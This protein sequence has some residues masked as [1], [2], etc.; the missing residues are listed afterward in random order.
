MRNYLSV[1]VAMALSLSMANAKNFNIDQSHS[2]VG[3]EVKH[4]L[5]S[6]VN[7]EFNNFSGVLDIDPTTKKI[8]KLEGQVIINSIDTKNKKR[9]DHLNSAD[10]FNSSKIQTGTFVMTKQDDEKIHGNLTLNGV[11]KPVE[12]EIE[13]NGP[14]SHPMTKKQLMALDIEGKINR[15]DFNIGNSFANSVVSD[16]IKVSIQIEAS[17]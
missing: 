13:I 4:L 16:E 12:W 7:G 10:F 3:F 17:E 15:K 2:S 1:A 5:L 14:I 9:D 11:T 8:N 6:K